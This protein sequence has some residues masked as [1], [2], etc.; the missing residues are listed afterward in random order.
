LL[1]PV[2]PQTPYAVTPDGLLP[3]QHKY[4]LDPLDTLTF[5][6]AHIFG[7]LADEALHREG[8]YSHDFPTKRYQRY[9]VSRHFAIAAE[10]GSV[11]TA[12]FLPT[13]IVGS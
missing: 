10:V 8:S 6:A 4:I 2:K 11:I 1:W 3:E 7:Q 9:H 13:G 12:P 5:A